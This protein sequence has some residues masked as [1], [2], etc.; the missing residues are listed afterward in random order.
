MHGGNS[1]P[2]HYINMVAGQFGGNMQMAFEKTFAHKAVSA[3]HRRHLDAPVVDISDARL[4]LRKERGHCECHGGVRDVIT[5][6][7]DALQAAA[8][9]TCTPTAS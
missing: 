4:P 9:G 6:V 5:V 2:L 7:I 1:L 8:R 3:G